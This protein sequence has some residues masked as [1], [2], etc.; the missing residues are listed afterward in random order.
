[1]DTRL[2]FLVSRR[3][4]LDRAAAVLALGP[5]HRLARADPLRRRLQRQQSQHVCPPTGAALNASLVSGVNYAADVAVSGNTL[6]IS[7][8]NSTTVGAY[9]AITGVTI[10]TN[11]ITGL[12][13]PFQLAVSGAA[14]LRRELCHRRRWPLQRADGHRHQ[15][16]VP[17]FGQ[18]VS[19]DHLR[20]RTVHPGC[21]GPGRAR[22]GHR[23]PAP[24]PPA[25]GFP[26]RSVC[27][28]DSTEDR[29][30]LIAKSP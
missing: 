21:F 23:D 22:A 29:E 13:N 27:F 2:R 28:P 4:A 17:Q 9:N 19:P 26:R 12:N 18:S 14:L 1:M 16:D 11:F 8:L 6:Y 3:L 30:A 10:K 5:I 7:N 25:P 24:T 20:A 15:R